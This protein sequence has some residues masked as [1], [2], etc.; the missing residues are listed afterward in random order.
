GMI[1]AKPLAAQFR[2]AEHDELLIGGN[3][4]LDVIQIEPAKDQRLTEGIRVRFLQS[5]LEYSSAAEATK[6]CL[7]YNARQ[8]NWFIAFFA[9]KFRKLMPIFVTTR[10]MGEQ[11][12]DGDDA[13]T[14]HCQN[15]R[16]RNPIDL[17]E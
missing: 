9:R 4:F 2:L 14:P 5:R 13:E 8:T 6:R 15:F 10:I 3:H 7:D 11:M 16:T 17:L 1:H 12:F